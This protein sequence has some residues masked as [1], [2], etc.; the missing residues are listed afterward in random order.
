MGHIHSNSEY[1]FTAAAMIVHKDKV[2]LLLHHKLQLW[3]PPAGH[4]ELDET[5]V[6]ALY[7]EVTEET[8][9]TKD[10]LTLVTP[11]KDNLEFERDQTG[12]TEPLPFDIEMHVVGGTG[13]HRHIDLCYIFISDTGEVVREEEKADQLRWFTL[14]EVEQLSP[15][16]R[17]I[18]S[19]ANY[20]L[21][22]VQEL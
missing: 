9:L 17:S 4:V 16:P 22:K 7:R 2:L 10:H 11:F 8:G 18:Y 5:P 21:K 12:R 3:L 13:G 20:A 15:M 19:R 14:A 6:E 1:D